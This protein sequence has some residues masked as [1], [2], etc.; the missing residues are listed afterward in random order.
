MPYEMYVACIYA[1]LCDSWWSVVDGSTLGPQ[2]QLFFLSL[3]LRA[4]HSWFPEV[5]RSKQIPTRA[6]QLLKSFM[7]YVVQSRGLD[8][9]CS[10]ASSTTSPVIY[11]NL[12]SRHFILIL[13][14][15]WVRPR[16]SCRCNT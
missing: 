1:A 10:M 15:L 3:R 11:C 9:S 8:G 2:H 6:L 4:A 13:S 16:S 14:V 7:S 5:H 12:Y